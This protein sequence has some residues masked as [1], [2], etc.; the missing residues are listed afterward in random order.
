M[1]SIDRSLAHWSLHTVLCLLI[2]SH[3]HPPTYRIIHTFI[4]M[5]LPNHLRGQLPAN[6]Q[7]HRSFMRSQFCICPNPLTHSFNH[8]LDYSHIPSLIR[9]IPISHIHS[10]STLLPAH[11]PVLHVIKNIFA[12]TTQNVQQKVYARL[13]VRNS[14]KLSWRTCI[15]KLIYLNYYSKF[16]FITCYVP[17]NF[18][19]IH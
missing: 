15:R 11:W 16:I 3:I 5:Y 7:W 9:S 14:Y 19:T 12:I 2:H 13:I 17:F 8:A 1:T 6:T 4:H 18:I 10:P